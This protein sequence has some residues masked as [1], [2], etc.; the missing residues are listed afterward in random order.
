M[1]ERERLIKRLD[2]E[3]IFA[4]IEPGSRV[5]DL[6]C[7][8]GDLLE[9]LINEKDVRGQ[10][11]EI[12]RE[13]VPRCVEKGVSVIHGDFYRE[14][15]DYPSNR[16]DYVILNESLQETRAVTLLLD[17]ALRV[18]RRVI[19]GFPNFAHIRMRFELFF[20]GRAPRTST[21]PHHWHDSPNLR[22]MSVSDFSEYCRARLIRIEA[23]H[24]FDNRR[25]VRVWPNLRATRAIFVLHR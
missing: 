13:K 5:L 10:G 18:G 9:R 25:R 1:T 2:N 6:G 14:L 22:F 7:G 19:V 4:V 17:E 12:D 24:F 3:L 15:A 23:T 16:F 21:L 20:L 8:E 11:I